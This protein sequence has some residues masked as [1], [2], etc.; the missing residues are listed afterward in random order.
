MSEAPPTE[1][2]A[3]PPPEWLVDLVKWVGND[4]WGFVTKLLLVLSPLFLLS[5]FLAYKLSQ[6]IESK[7]KHQKQAAK[8]KQNVQKLRKKRTKAD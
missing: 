8:R 7:E 6:S 1:N 2:P 3:S 4:P 5:A